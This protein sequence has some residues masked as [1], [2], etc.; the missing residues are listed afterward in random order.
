MALRP[1]TKIIVLADEATFAIFQTA[2]WEHTLLNFWPESIL[3]K[4]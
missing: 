1:V 4:K 3:A 2:G